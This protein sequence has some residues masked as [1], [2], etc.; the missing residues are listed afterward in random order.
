[1]HVVCPVQTAAGGAHGCGLQSTAAGACGMLTCVHQKQ[2]SLRNC[3]CILLVDNCCRVW[4][5]EVSSEA[6]G[7][8]QPF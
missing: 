2:L 5:A 4:Q 7:L 3:L 6:A 8:L 1:M